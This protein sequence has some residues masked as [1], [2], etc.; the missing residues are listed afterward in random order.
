MDRTENLLIRITKIADQTFFAF[1]RI[2]VAVSG[3]IMVGITIMITLG[4]FARTFTDW[5]FLFVEEWGALALIPISYLAFGYVLR[6]DRHL[7]MDLLVRA[8]PK[9]I[10]EVFAIFSGVFGLFVLAFIIQSAYNSFMYT[11][12]RQVV[13]SGPMQTPLWIF[14]LVI[15]IGIALFTID[16]ILFLA[17]HIIYVVKGK[18]V[19]HFEDIDV[20]PDK[21]EGGTEV[22]N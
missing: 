14:N 18:R 2:C 10:K 6:R 7:K 16:M 12:V 5:V 21:M 13:S 1:S 9:S 8:V 11:W 19:Y 15:L 17:N 4:V 20:E 3:I 22:C